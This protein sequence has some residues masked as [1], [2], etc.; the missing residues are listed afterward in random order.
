[1]I[2]TYNSKDCIWCVG[3]EESS[4]HLFVHCRMAARVWD[5]ILSWCGISFIT[6]HNMFA[7]V[8]CCFAALRG[9]KVCRGF[10]SFGTRPFGC[11][12]ELG[13]IGCLIMK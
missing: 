9:K 7:Q 6:P 11:C 4:I 5:K 1:M 2:F 12:R 13:T 10:R 3:V 8:E